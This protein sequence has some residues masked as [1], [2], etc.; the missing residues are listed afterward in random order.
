MQRKERATI[1]ITGGG[2]NGNHSS[3]SSHIKTDWK[4][5]KT[6]EE[7]IP[8]QLF[9]QTMNRDYCTV[10]REEGCER[11]TGCLYA[12]GNCSL[13]GAPSWRT[14][15]TSKFAFFKTPEKAWKFCACFPK[16]EGSVHKAFF[17]SAR[18]LVPPTFEYWHVV[19]YLPGVYC[20]SCWEE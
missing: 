17:L 19:V 7:F 11:G 2:A 13:T 5:Q 1:A 20:R 6:P 8:L 14:R 4:A 18:K 15:G 16:L 12:S 10:R 3:Q 9:S